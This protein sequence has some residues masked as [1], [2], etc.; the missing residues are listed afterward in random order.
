MSNKDRIIAKR[1]KG[2]TW[3]YEFPTG[4]MG[5]K[6]D[7]IIDV[8]ENYFNDTK[9]GG[10]FIISPREGTICTVKKEQKPLPP[11]PP[12]EEKIYSIFKQGK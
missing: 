3:K 12:P 10:D 1:I 2:N 5:I 11:P 6:F 9:Y 7:S 8:L 4:K